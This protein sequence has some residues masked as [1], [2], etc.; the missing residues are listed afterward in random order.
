MGLHDGAAGRGSFASTAHV[1]RL[2]AAPVILVIDTT[3]QGRSAAALAL[4]M[5]VFDPRVRLAGVI[6][7]RVGTPRHEALLRE[8]L[9]E[10]D[11]PV[12]GA[13]PR[14]ARVA[15]PSRHLG[16]IPAAERASE[17]LAAIGELA[18]LVEA[19]VD[20]DAVLA[21]ARQALP[22]TVDPWDPAAELGGP[23]VAGRPRIALAGGAAFTFSYA[24]TA[25]LLAAAGAE[26]VSFDPLRDQ[27]LP[28]GSRA[29][30]IGGGFP[31][32]Y[33]EALS[34]NGALRAQVAE[35]DGPIVGECAGLLYLGKNLDQVPMC[36]RLP[37]TARMTPKLTLGYREAVAATES[38]LTS[39]GKTV[40]G[41]EFH[42]TACDPPHGARPAWDWNGVPQGFV[43]GRV[44]ASYLHLHWAGCPDLARRLALACG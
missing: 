43:S 40:R 29:M 3:A 13:V 10:V 17:A 31:E 39:A 20:L 35:F 5:R 18:D 22:L 8:A 4:G 25:E 12:L 26:V 19:T 44:H 6:L 9:A 42:R 28:A 2:L 11:L 1:A 24:E 21:I 37:S 27:R 36:G 23:V 34:A 7:N 32:L 15:A 38:F 14:A 41:H 16:L 33:A 30:I